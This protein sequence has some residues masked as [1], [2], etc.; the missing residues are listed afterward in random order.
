MVK[1]KPI[2]AE[3]PLETTTPAAEASSQS[4]TS[5][6]NPTTATVTDVRGNPDRTYSLEVHGE[7]FA[8]L[9]EGYAKKRGWTVQYA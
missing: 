6:K 7:G 1:K 4:A 9:A 8:A 2:T 3:A 5:P